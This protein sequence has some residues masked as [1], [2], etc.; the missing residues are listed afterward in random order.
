VPYFKYRVRSPGASGG[1]S[2]EA[3]LIDPAEA[4]AADPFD[5]HGAGALLRRAD[6]TPRLRAQQKSVSCC[7]LP[8]SET[9]EPRT[10]R[11]TAFARAR[12]IAREGWPGRLEPL[13]LAEHAQPD[14]RQTAAKVRSTTEGGV[15]RRSQPTGKT[16]RTLLR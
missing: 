15:A 10:A 3:A 1:F 8:R 2:R 5:R 7:R 13:N 6:E 4:E 11:A 16:S 12:A 14:A 9:G